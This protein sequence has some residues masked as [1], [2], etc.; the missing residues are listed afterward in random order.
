MVREGCEVTDAAMAGECAVRSSSR[1]T[2]INGIQAYT[3]G[4]LQSKDK[5]FVALWRTEGG[6]RA[7]RGHAAC[8][9]R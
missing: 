4:G 9:S 6:S 7:E 5:W 1:F 3:L 2:R 8:W